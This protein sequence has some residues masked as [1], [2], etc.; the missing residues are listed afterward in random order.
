MRP[1]KLQISQEKPDS[2]VNCLQGTVRDLACLGGST[3]YRVETESGQLVEVRHANLLHS[4][5]R[6]IDW[7]DAVWL[8]WSERASV[9]LED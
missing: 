9:I 7:D 5:V 3:V 2:N 6:E 1:E 4:A 8:S